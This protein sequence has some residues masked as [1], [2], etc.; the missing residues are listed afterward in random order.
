[1][2]FELREALRRLC[3]EIGWSY[4][5]FWRLIDSPGPKHLVW[6]DGYW[7]GKPQLSGL[8][9]AVAHGNSF[10][11]LQAQGEGSIDELVNK[12]MV[13][14][15]H[16]LGDGMVGVAAVSGNYQWILRELYGDQETM[17]EDLA[18]LNNQFSAGI[19]TIVVIP[20]P[21]HGAIQL[22]STKRWNGNGFAQP[23]VDNASQ[24]LSTIWNFT[25]GRSQRRKRVKESMKLVWS[26]NK[27]NPYGTSVKDLTRAPMSS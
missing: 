7:C 25:K 1:M 14:Q 5:V 9:D 2:V 17:A 20:V 6:H 10:A 19:Q 3:V 4:A 18:F 22:G 16:V 12:T 27:F 26:L 21:P 15:V 24:N 23:Q 13:P 11:V 8:N